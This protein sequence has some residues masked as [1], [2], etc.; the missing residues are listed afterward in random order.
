MGVPVADQLKQPPLPPDFAHVMYWLAEL[1][2]PVTWP[3]LLA[4]QQVTGRDLA[5]WEID[6]LMRLDRV[7]Q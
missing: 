6:L 4:W 5:R 3:D 1:P 2:C 7:R